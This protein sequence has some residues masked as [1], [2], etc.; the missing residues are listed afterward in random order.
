[1]IFIAVSTQ[2]LDAYL[3]KLQKFVD[4]KQLVVSC[5]KG[6]H[7]AT[8]KFPSELIKEHWNIEKGKIAI[9][10]G[11][12]F[13]DGV[14]QD[15]YTAFGIATLEKSTF[16]RVDAILQRQNIIRV[17]HNSVK[18]LELFGA[19][20][21]AY[22]IGFGIL[23]ACKSSSNAEAVYIAAV[24][25][26]TIQFTNE[27]CASSEIPFVSFA[28]LVMT[29]TSPKSR[30]H[31]YGLMM[32]SGDELPKF[33]CEGVYTAKAMRKY[34]EKRKLTFPVLNCIVEQIECKIAGKNESKTIEKVI[35]EAC[36]RSL[37]YFCKA[38]TPL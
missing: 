31:Q 27:L 15:N 13:A 10:S 9:L 3:F 2:C 14:M 38:K 24:S 28:D 8:G 23:K 36:K 32:G 7:D 4:K 17:L 33:L 37:Q 5:C 30:N 25:G 16:L 35:L 21:N 34:A 6:I 19:L 26:E 18:G 1:M 20:K 22:A 11:P 29:C 12:S